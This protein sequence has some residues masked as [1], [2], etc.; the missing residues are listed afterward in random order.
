MDRIFFIG[1]ALFAA[2]LFLA[3]LKILVHGLIDGT[4]FRDIGK[5]RGDWYNE[6]GH[7]KV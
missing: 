7:G 3:P 4:F 2:I 5:D 6:G 1:I